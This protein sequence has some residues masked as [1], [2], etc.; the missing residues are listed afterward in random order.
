MTLIKNGKEVKSIIMGGTR[1]DESL[2]GYFVGDRWID[3]Y[4]TQNPPIEYKLEYD[5]DQN[6]TNH[7]RRPCNIRFTISNNIKPMG[8]S[9]IIATYEFNG[10]LYL[11]CIGARWSDDDNITWFNYSE[12]RD[13]IHK[14][15]GVNSTLLTYLYQAL[16]HTFTGK[17]VSVC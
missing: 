6:G 7:T 14:I 16:K 8:D 4:R 15:G 11:G 9:Y 2:I 3:D 12:V 10:E 1:F 13:I 5:V 17:K